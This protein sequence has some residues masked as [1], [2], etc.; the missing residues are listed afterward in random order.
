MNTEVAWRL[1]GVRTLTNI[2]TY[3]FYISLALVPVAL[4]FDLIE[5]NLLISIPDATYDPTSDFGS[6]AEASDLRQQIMGSVQ[7]AISVANFILWFVWIF[8][9]NKL[10]QAFGASGMKYSPGWSIGWYFVP[11]LNLFHPY[12]AMKE[13]YLASLSPKQFDV[14]RDVTEQPESLN[15]VGMWWL[16]WIVDSGI[17][18]FA[19]RYSIKAEAIDELVFST[20]LIMCSELSSVAIA[21]A[22][23]LLLKHMRAAQENSAAMAAS[24]AAATLSAEAELPEPAA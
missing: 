12:L 21:V 1:A 23:L 11:I 22:S 8:K 4:V 3:L 6:K 10:A 7:I 19:F 15:F 5:Y 18:K 14:N 17:S 13:L 2:V 24:D 9:S 20:K 16:F